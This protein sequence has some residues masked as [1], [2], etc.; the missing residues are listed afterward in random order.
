MDKESLLRMETITTKDDNHVGD[1]DG[2]DRNDGDE[3][4]EHWSS[5][6][7]GCLV[8]FWRPANAKKLRSKS[9]FINSQQHGK[10]ENIPLRCRLTFQL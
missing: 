2:D 4:F 10:G 5:L 3:D 8:H 6:L 1:N 9:I 7:Q